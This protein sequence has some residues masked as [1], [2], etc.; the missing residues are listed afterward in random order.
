MI[1]LRGVSINAGGSTL[2]DI[3]FEVGRGAYAVIMGKTG[4]GKTTIM[5]SICGLRRVTAGKVLLGGS[6]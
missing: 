5:E 4:C 3:S 6:T 2:R 1:E